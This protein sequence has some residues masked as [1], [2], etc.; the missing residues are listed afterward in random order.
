M[1][2]VGFHRLFGGWEQFMLVGRECVCVPSGEG[3]G[4]LG[5]ILLD[6]F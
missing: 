5:N 4:G 6:C 3:G 2:C 1:L